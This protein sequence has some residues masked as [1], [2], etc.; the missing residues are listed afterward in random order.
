MNRAMSGDGRDCCQSAS[1][2]WS[3]P[4]MRRTP[5]AEPAPDMTNLRPL[6]VNTIIDEGRWTLYQRWLVGLTALTIVFDGMDNQLLGIT[7]PQMMSAFGVARSAFSPVVALGYLGMSI[8]GAIAGLAGDRAGRRTA[9]LGSMAIFGVATLGVSSVQSIPP[10]HLPVHRGHR[11]R[12]RDT[13]RGSARSRIRPAEPA[14]HRRDGHDRL[15]AAGRHG[16]GLVAI[17][18]LPAHGL[19]RL[20]VVG[21]SFRSS[22]RRA[23]TAAAGIAA[24]SR[25]P[26][27]RDG[28]S[29]SQTLRRMGHAVPA[30]SD[31][32]GTS[33]RV[34]GPPVARRDLPAGDRLGHAGAVG[35]IL[36]LPA[37]GLSR[38]QLAAH[39]HHRRRTRIGHGEQRHHSVQSGRGRRRD[40]GRHPD[41]TTRIQGDDAGAGRERS[42]VPRC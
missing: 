22:P 17:P 14:P 27:R 4:T 39:H 13:E 19:A 8:G 20:F 30:G 31:L 6:D 15:R 34:T 29:S 18:L 32:R 11:A 25:A 33:P 37:R 40:C 23:P 38:I 35:S 3:P 7:I 1:L 5:S 21:G 26:S 42:S 24:L 9:L 28:T 10:W 16:G 2:S 12:R 36:L 41:R